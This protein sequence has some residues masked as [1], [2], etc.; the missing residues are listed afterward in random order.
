MMFPL[1]CGEAYQ[2]TLLHQLIEHLR[3]E[4]Q[5]H[6]HRQ[7]TDPKQDPAACKPVEEC[8]PRQAALGEAKIITRLSGDDWYEFFLH[9]TVPIVAATRETPPTHVL[10]LHQHQ[11][12][13]SWA[14]IDQT[15]KLIN[16][17]DLLIPWHVQPRPGTRSYSD[18]YAFEVA[19]QIVQLAVQ[20]HALIAIQN[21]WANKKTSTSAGRNQRTFAHPS[22]KVYDLV[23]YKAL[24]AGLP[25][26]RHVYGVSPRHCG[27]CGNTRNNQIGKEP[28]KA[29]PACGSLSRA[30][31]VQFPLASLIPTPG[32]DPAAW[33]LLAQEQEDGVRAAALA[34][35]FYWTLR[36]GTEGDH[37]LA[38]TRQA[39]IAGLEQVQ[40]QGRHI[41]QAK[42]GRN[43][44][45]SR[46]QQRENGNRQPAFRPR[47]LETDII[48]AGPE[49][50]EPFFRQWIEAYEQ[51][52][53]HVLITYV[54]TTRET[55]LEML[56]GDED[57]EAVDVVILDAP[58]NERELV[59]GV[60]QQGRWFCQ[61]CGQHW[62]VSESWFRCTHQSCRHDDL[63]RYNTATVAAQVALRKLV[64]NCQP[65]TKR[66]P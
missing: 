8:L 54:S 31:H 2:E 12:G 58:A 3:V 57:A 4:Q 62:Q 40:W 52:A 66:T 56:Y 44:H 59:A 9:C 65:S 32:S 55:A 43:H 60:A 10:G 35:F 16:T 64:E 48:I 38:E 30:A 17:G 13:Y 49:T 45:T 34:D 63:A 29:C 41:F 7:Y 47:Q 27:K 33:V 39:F 21:T 42:T 50:W 15:G 23:V 25:R 6:Y 28:L 19:D 37:P 53:P 18:N 1:E 5:A 26:P 61:D 11:H 24:E 51:V 22:R 36:V 46:I 14:L 20:H